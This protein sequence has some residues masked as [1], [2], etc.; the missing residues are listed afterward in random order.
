MTQVLTTATKW[1]PCSWAVGQSARN[2]GLL[3]KGEGG[4]GTDVFFILLW[5]Q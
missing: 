2:W 3:V 4:T 5:R 1:D